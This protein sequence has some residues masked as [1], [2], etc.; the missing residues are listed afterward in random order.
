MKLVGFRGILRSLKVSVTVVKSRSGAKL[1]SDVG[2]RLDAGES[3]S[4]GKFPSM[5]IATV[6]LTDR[7]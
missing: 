4:G 3:P 7:E 2:F 1:I 5:V 6:L